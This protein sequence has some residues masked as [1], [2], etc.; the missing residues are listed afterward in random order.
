MKK[1]SV[2]VAIA[3]AA[4]AA[5]GIAVA[6][7]NHSSLSDVQLANIEALS[8]GEGKVLIPCFSSAIESRGR[9]Y[10]ACDKCL[11]VVG[12]EGTGTE[13]WCEQNR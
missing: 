11:K 1:K 10:T 5:A 7:S 13:A 2:I 4:L 9:S 12:W 3:F 8:R 6:D